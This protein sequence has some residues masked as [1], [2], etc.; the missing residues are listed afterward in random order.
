MPHHGVV[1]A[2]YQSKAASG[3]TVFPSP[4]AHI[5]HSC[6]RRLPSNPVRPFSCPGFWTPAAHP[7]L[8]APSAFSNTGHATR[9][10]SR[11][12]PRGDAMS[13]DLEA[14]APK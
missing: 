10:R 7:G 9:L 1:I 8:P 11:L 12:H 2:T 6:R 4:A 14:K 5:Q 3:V 13:G